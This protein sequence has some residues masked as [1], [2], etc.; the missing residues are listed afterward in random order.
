MPQE[1]YGSTQVQE[2]RFSPEEVR[3]IVLE[4]I[5]HRACPSYDFDWRSP[6]ILTDARTGELIFR[7]IQN[8]ITGDSE[9]R[10]ITLK[11]MPADKPKKAGPNP[12]AK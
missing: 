8:T 2:L 9:C 12:N 4:N 10:K 11:E 1:Q 7:F 3:A 6:I 5:Q